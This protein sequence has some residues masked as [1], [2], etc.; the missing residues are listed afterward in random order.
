VIE[1]FGGG[2]GSTAPYSLRHG[3]TTSLNLVAAVNA[4]PSL[5]LPLELSREPI[6]LRA[7]PR[8]SQAAQALVEFSCCGVGRLGAS[9]DG[10][11]ELMYASIIGQGGRIPPSHAEVGP[12]AALGGHT[13]WCQRQ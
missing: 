8:L 1:I 4:V 10:Q 13:C 5:A 7:A 9:T 2:D 11:D 6:E 3:G 12:F